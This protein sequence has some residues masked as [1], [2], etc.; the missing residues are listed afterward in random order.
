MG[1]CPPLPLL[2]TTTIAPMWFLV[3]FS[4]ALAKAAPRLLTQTF[5]EHTVPIVMGTSY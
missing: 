3:M 5:R 2:S 1:F 4:T